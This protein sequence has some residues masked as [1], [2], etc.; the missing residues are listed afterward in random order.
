MNPQLRM[1][2]QSP[3]QLF[4]KQVLTCSTIWME[5]TND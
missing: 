5:Q 2:E 1:N 3:F 4:E